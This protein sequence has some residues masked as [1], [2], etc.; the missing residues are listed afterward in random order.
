MKQGWKDQIFSNS[1]HNLIILPLKIGA[2]LH[3]INNFLCH[4]I[5]LTTLSP[6]GFKVNYLEDHHSLP[7]WII[8]HLCKKDL[9]KRGDN[10]LAI[11]DMVYKQMDKSS[12]RLARVFWK[13]L[14]LHWVKHRQKAD[15]VLHKKIKT[16]LVEVRM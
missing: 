3:L 12:R 10:V 5:N 11:N 13:I 14:S 2:T 16:K 7:T 6:A 8:V 4:L 1:F 9:Q 15:L